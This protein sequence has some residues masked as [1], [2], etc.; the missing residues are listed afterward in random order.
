MEASKSDFYLKSLCMKIF[1]SKWMVNQRTTYIFDCH[2]YTHTFE[3]YPTIFNKCKIINSMHRFNSKLSFTCDIA[4]KLKR[5]HLWHILCKCS[6]GQFSVDTKSS[7]FKVTNGFKN[8][9]L[10]VFAGWEPFFNE[11]LSK[12]SLLFI[13]LIHVPWC[14]HREILCQILLFWY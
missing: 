7:F 13:S 9:C 8:Y 12:K 10:H 11:I 6:L 4:K 1:C 14:A 3:S 2:T 5:I